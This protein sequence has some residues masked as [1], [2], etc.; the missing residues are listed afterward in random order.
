M[1]KSLVALAVVSLL[2]GA[3]AT[4]AQAQGVIQVSRVTLNCS[5]NESALVVGT[6]FDDADAGDDLDAG[7]RVP[8]GEFVLT[9]NPGETATHTFPSPI[10][11]VV[12]TDLDVWY[13]YITNTATTAGVPNVCIDDDFATDTAYA[14]ELP[15]NANDDV[16]A[17]AGEQCEG[18]GG[19][20]DVTLGASGDFTSL[21]FESPTFNPA[22]QA[23]L[24]TA[25]V[26][27]L[28]LGY[29]QAKNITLSKI[30][31]GDPQVLRIKE[32]TRIFPPGFSQIFSGTTTNS[33]GDLTADP[34]VAVAL[35]TP[36]Q[37]GGADGNV[38]D[39][40]SIS[41]ITTLLTTTAP[42]GGPWCLVA[43]SDFPSAPGQDQFFRVVLEVCNAGGCREVSLFIRVRRDV[44][45][46]SLGSAASRSEPLA[47]TGV[48]ARGLLQAG[49]PLMV[50]VQGR[51]IAST[52]LKVYDLTGRQIAAVKAQGAT[53]RWQ[54]S[55]R[56]GRPLANGVYLYVVEVKGYDGRVI[57]TEVR[58][59]VVLR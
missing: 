52:T 45:T 11:S 7:E 19:T 33:A 30:T 58:K 2:I 42:G 49:Q 25:D 51:G 17:A 37:D 4:L 36:G 1:K 34:E 21:I 24:L 3:M 28:V 13:T 9:C 14:L 43:E 12:F 50:S 20:G 56:D 6:F 23:P 29:D 46:A 31:G 26:F 57:R 35:T 10:S 40:T 5:P 39:A 59:L 44:A 32:F 38:C 48:R 47:V 16:A 22:Q 27:A 8:G 18:G 41:G 53:L 54:P 55:A 15:S